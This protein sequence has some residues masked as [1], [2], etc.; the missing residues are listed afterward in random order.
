MSTR[1]PD[2]VSIWRRFTETNLVIEIRLMLLKVE[3]ERGEKVRKPFLRRESNP[4]RS[5]ESAES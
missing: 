5:G 3:R 4:G 2:T 1:I